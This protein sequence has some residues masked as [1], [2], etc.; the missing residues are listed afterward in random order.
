MGDSVLIKKPDAPLIS[1]ASDYSYSAS[2]YAGPHYRIVGDAA[3][4]SF[5]I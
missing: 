2:Y 1:A 4:Q 3:G 5:S